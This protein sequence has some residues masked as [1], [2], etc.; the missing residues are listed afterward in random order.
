[1]KIPLT[2]RWIVLM[3]AAVVITVSVGLIGWRA[4]VRSPSEA[5]FYQD[6][7][8]RGKADEWTALGGTWEVM[9]GLMR[10]DS[11]ERGAKLITG[12]PRWRNYSV[13]ADISL[14][15]QGDAGLIIRSGREEEGVDAYSGYYSG[16]RTID[17]SLVLGRAEHGWR[18]V[19]K[20]ASI[21]G[22]IRPFARYHLKLLAYGCQIVAAITSAP[23]PSPESIAITDPI[24]VPSGRVG[25]RSYRSG[26]T[27]SNVVVRPADHDDLM[28]MLS[29][30]TDRGVRAPGLPPASNSA[31]APQVSLPEA[32]TNVHVEGIESLRLTYLARPAVATIRGV[33]I[34]NSPML[35]VQD[36]TGG[37]YVKQHYSPNLKVGDEVEVTG[38]VRPGEFSSVIDNA[39]IRVLWEGIPM[40]P[41]AVTASQASA[42]KF[43]ATFIEVQGRLAAKERGPENTLILD[44]EEAG[45]SFRAIMNPGRSA[46]V[47]DRLKT[48]SR[49]SLRGICVVD[50]AITKNL[51]PFVLL[52]RSSDDVNVLA[53][54]PWWNTGHV[55]ALLAALLLLGVV[56]VFVYQ[57]V[58]NW[59][60]RAVLEERERLAHE[61][62]DTLAQSFAGIGF[63]LQAIR[64]KLPERE[65]AVHQQLEL[66]SNLVRHSHDEAR[67]SIAMLRPQSLESEDLLSALD[68]HARR[69]VEGG[70][71]RVISERSGDP[72]PIPLRVAD[73]LFRV[74]QESIANSLRH[75][76]P[77]V[78][79]IRLHYSPNSASL[80]V[81]DNGTGFN[82]E[83]ALQ[84][85]GIRGMRRRAQTV[86]ATLRVHSTPGEG[87][88]IEVQAP[89]PPH[90]TLA[91][92]PKFLWK[93]LMESWIYVRPSKFSN[94]HSY[95]G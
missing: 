12:S 8:A 82:P 31:F 15:G 92:W 17:D 58:E 85:F 39:T 30:E 77:A 69:L 95:R 7:F 27:W 75:A 2:T 64:N 90:L 57:R 23:H 59:R 73:T 52:L 26:G 74:G 34:L 87:T 13:E 43:D 14:L 63:Q 71:V 56:S 83:A 55:I 45:Q 72:R 32:R 5:H 20:K 65:A 10:N 46:Y 70:A 61:M 41:V 68:Q 22:G 49:V 76:N 79:R 93:Y 44:L 53:G 89:L 48:G 66:A 25:L 24:C 50:P 67:R 42:G 11:D 33:V 19:T 47:F 51:T 6:S 78:L 80:E 62:H 4:Y 35:F 9:N 91:T 18:E 54:P 1:M 16:M 36:S 28:A 88:L 40:A 3:G 29:N 38:M 94:S 37:V 60:L 81:E 21:P 86:S 84:G